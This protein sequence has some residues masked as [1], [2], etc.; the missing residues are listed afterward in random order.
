MLKAIEKGF[1]ALGFSG[2]S[3]T[4]FDGSY[5]MTEDGTLQYIKEINRLREK[6]RDE[7]RIYLGF[8]SGYFCRKY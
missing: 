8:G 4:F 2:H 3:Y 1:S 5:C 6:Y 7:I